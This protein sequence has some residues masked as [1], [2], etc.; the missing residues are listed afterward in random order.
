MIDAILL[1]VTC[2]VTNNVI[3]LTEGRNYTMRAFLSFINL[4]LFTD[5]LCRIL[6]VV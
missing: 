1:L 4:S 2:W 6:D 5:M 3:K